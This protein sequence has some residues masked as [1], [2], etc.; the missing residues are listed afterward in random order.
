MCRKNAGHGRIEKRNCTVVSY[1]SI[2]EKMFKKKLV[3]LKSV[4]GIKS[5]RTIVAT[6]E[7]TQEV[8]YYVTSLDN[9]QPE[10][11]ILNR[12]ML[13]DGRCNLLRLGIIK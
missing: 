2:M 6:G 4:V 3:G 1:G 12:P 9:T 8:R 11:I 7:Y 13:P 10:K 5:E